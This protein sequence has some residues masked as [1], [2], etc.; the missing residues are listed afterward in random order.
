MNFTL[1]SIDM[2]KINELSQMNFRIV[3]KQKVPWAPDWD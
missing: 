1:S 2:A 3:D